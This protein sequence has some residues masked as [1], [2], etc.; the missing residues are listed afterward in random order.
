MSPDD[1]WVKS[2]TLLLVKGALKFF[3]QIA[4]EGIAIIPPSSDDQSQSLDAA[5]G[6][7]WYYQT[8]L[9]NF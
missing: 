8:H 1:G 6:F 5:L 7:S 4:V 2:T 3:S 9:E